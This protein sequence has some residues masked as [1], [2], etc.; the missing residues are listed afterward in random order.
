MKLYISTLG[1]FDIELGDKSLLRDASRSYKLFKLFQYF[2]TF[3]NNKI[4]PDTIIDNLWP[5]HESYDPH[6][7]LRAQIYRLRQL[8]KN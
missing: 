3:R 5:D 8:M 6:N 4:L 2:L 7:M 1:V